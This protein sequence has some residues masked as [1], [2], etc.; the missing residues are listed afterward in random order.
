MRFNQLTPFSFK[1]G[2]TVLVSGKELTVFLLREW[3]RG[4]H[5]GGTGRTHNGRKTDPVP[6]KLLKA[7]V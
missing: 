4:G 7:V 1:I 3:V 2:N 5:A 6:L